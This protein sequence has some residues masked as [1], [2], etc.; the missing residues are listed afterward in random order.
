MTNLEQKINDFDFD[1][2]FTKEFQEQIEKEC[3]EDRIK[4][5][6]KKY[7]RIMKSLSMEVKDY[8]TLNTCKRCQGSG[9]I[10]SYRHVANGV[11]FKC[12]GYGKC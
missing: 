5:E 8:T 6:Q 1:S 7:E 11:C 2:L 9:E 10:K 4:E 3:Q 12:G